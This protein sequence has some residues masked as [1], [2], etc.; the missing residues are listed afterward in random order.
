MLIV[1]AER[2]EEDSGGRDFV[3]GVISGVIIG[4]MINGLISG[5]AYVF[6]ISRAYSIIAA[7]SFD[8]SIANCYISKNFDSTEETDL[9]EARKRERRR[10]AKGGN[11][12]SFDEPDPA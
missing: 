12:E 11:I 3:I 6:L 2:K 9:A 4:Y 7:L 10:L 1:L 8:L 5:L